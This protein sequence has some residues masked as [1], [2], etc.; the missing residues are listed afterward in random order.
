MLYNP[1]CGCDGNIYPSACEAYYF[2]GITSWLSCDSISIDS[3]DQ[4]CKG[5]TIELLAQGG[6]TYLW[7][8]G[9]VTKSIYVSPLISTTYTVTI[10]YNGAGCEL[11]TSK[12]I[13]VD[14][15]YLM[16]NDTI[17][18]YGD[19]IRIGENEYNLP[20]RYSDTLTTVSGCDSIIN[21]NIFLVADSCLIT[22]YDTIRFNVVDTIFFYDTIQIIDTIRFNV[23]D[24]IFT[25][26]SIL[27][28]DTIT[29]IDTLY[30]SVVD[31]SGYLKI[32]ENDN[33]VLNI[34]PNPAD[35]YICIK[36]PVIIDSYS[37]Y[38]LNGEIIKNE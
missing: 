2:Y 20:G 6:N 25:Y 36:A 17:I 22:V 3:P 35:K 9:E 19:T 8:T 30:I 11:S 7:S 1:V 33:I 10:Q 14:T 31:S 18:L 16:I 26:D 4:I 24:T 37:L 21:T 27:I 13:Q 12:N 5:N 34:F 32:N 15:A 38:N 28:L 29:V 23:V